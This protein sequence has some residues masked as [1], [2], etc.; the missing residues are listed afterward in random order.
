VIRGF[1]L[2]TYIREKSMPTKT[3]KLKKASKRGAKHVAAPSAK[4]PVKG[5]TRKAGATRK[6]VKLAS[7]KTLTAKAL[8]AAAVSFVPVAPDATLA[9]L[10]RIEHVVVLMMENRSFDHV[11]GYL[12]IENGRTDV[13][14]LTKEMHNTYKSV[15][16][17]PKRRTAAAFGKKQD[18]VMPG[19]A[20]P[21]S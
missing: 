15:D 19:R 18:R 6:S 8:T 9:N 3:S 5:A 20:S 12:T 2:N 21:S 10:D 16:Y 11:L 7:K 1:N 4:R 13:D 14:G 17:F